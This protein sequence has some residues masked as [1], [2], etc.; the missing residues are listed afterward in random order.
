MYG[1]NVLSFIY[2]TKKDTYKIELENFILIFKYFE[3]LQK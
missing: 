1:I 3:Y 2:I